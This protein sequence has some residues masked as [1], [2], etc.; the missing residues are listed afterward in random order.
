MEK[1]E[2]R[3]RRQEQ[4]QGVC[5]FGASRCQCTMSFA[6]FGKFCVYF[7]DTLAH[8]HSH[9]YTQWDLCGR[10]PPLASMCP[11][12]WPT[13]NSGCNCDCGFVCTSFM[14]SPKIVQ[15]LLASNAATLRGLH[16]PLGAARPAPEC[17]CRI[18]FIKMSSHISLSICRQFSGFC[19]ATNC[20]MAARNWELASTLNCLFWP[21]FI[22]LFV[23]FSEPQHY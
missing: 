11:L 4:E 17:E 8:T 20:Q 3:Q 1:E 23:M 9:T 10:N 7:A 16:T 5:C 2:H 19:I 22:V 12:P 14:R 15:E 13:H 18:C 21:S 6:H